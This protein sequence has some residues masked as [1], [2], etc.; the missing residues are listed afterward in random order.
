MKQIVVTLVASI[1][2]FLAACDKGPSDIEVRGNKFAQAAFTQDTVTEAI[3]GFFYV[4]N[5][6]ILDIQLPAEGVATIEADAGEVMEKRVLLLRAAATSY[7]FTRILMFN[8]KTQKVIVTFNG[9]LSEENGDK[10]SHKVIT[11]EM[12]REKALTLNWQNLEDSIAKD[13]RFEQ[14]LSEFEITHFDNAF[15]GMLEAKLYGIIHQQ[16]K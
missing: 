13:K 4:E 6:K 1:S 10:T 14:V 15:D 9:T 2:L 11:T 16:A 12:N 5:F 7:A 8:E 3:N